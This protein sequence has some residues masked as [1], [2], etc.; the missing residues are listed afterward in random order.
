[1]A[2]VSKQAAA[3]TAADGVYGVAIRTLLLGGRRGRSPRN[4]PCCSLQQLQQL[5][6]RVTYQ[7]GPPLDW[8]NG[9]KVLQM[10]TAHSAVRKTC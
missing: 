4:R 5:L 7:G 2:G 3:P 1:M 9:C 8:E 6:A 10:D